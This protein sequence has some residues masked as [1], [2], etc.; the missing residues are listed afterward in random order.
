MHDLDNVATQ[1]ISQRV[2]SG[3][4]IETAALRA[5]LDPE[6]L[7]AAESAE[8]GLAED[9]LQ[10]LADVYGIGLSAFFGGQT[11]PISYLFGA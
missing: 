4:H 10:A 5:G 3:L 9:E 7:A 1:L 6:K 11:T 8:L 2:R